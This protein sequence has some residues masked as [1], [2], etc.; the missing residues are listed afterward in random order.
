MHTRRM[1]TLAD[2]GGSP[3][4]LI[5]AHHNDVARTNSRPRAT[6]ILPPRTVHSDDML[7]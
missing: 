1:L 6:M 7:P 4:S 3:G 5:E 2:V